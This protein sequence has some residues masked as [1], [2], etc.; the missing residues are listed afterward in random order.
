[1]GNDQNKPLISYTP[2]TLRARHDGW[3]AE[4]QV[5]FIEA[6]AETGIVDD[7]RGDA[8]RGP[9]STGMTGPPRVRA[10][11]RSLHSLRF[12]GPRSRVEE[13]TW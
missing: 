13:R 7:P 2:A 12:E 5:A 9:I 11:V 4:K 1:M 3:T 8:A 6:L 10:R